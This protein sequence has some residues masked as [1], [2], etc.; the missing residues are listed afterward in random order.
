MTLL[1]PLRRFDKQS[2]AQAELARL[3][4]E[5]K[6]RD[7][8]VQQLSQE[9]FRLVRDQV[10]TGGR[11][12]PAELKSLQQ[13]LQTEKHKS[14]DY[15]TRLQ[16]RETELLHLQNSVVQLN[17]RIQILEAALR[18]MPQ[19]Y[20]QKFAER[21]VP[22]KA[23]ILSLQQKNRDLQAELNSVSYRLAVRDRQ[24]AQLDLPSFPRFNAMPS[25]MPS[26]RAS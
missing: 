15:R 2:D 16:Q 19:I 1:P 21:M 25:A 4:S 17:S 12:L 23:K 9:L 22:V 13:Q 7:Q 18:E 6:L 11:R 5:L 3:Q 8:L 20:K 24:I 10:P 26:V 14:A